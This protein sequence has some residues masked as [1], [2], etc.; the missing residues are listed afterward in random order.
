MGELILVPFW[1]YTPIERKAHRLAAIKKLKQYAAVK[2]KI[3]FADCV[4]RDLIVGDEDAGDTANLPVDIQDAPAGTEQR[5]S[6]RGW[7]Q[8][9]SD[10]TAETLDLIYD[11]AVHDDQVIGIIGFVD[12]SGVGGVGTSGD[13]LYMRIRDRNNI[14]AF[15]NCQRVYAG[16][17][18]YGG[19]FVDQDTGEPGILVFDEND[20]LMIEVAVVTATTDRQVVFEALVAEKVGNILT[21]TPAARAV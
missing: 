5:T 4:V 19:Y 7:A 17:A 1:E 2:L 15:F 12:C 13:L 14:K 9:A 21:G 18:P 20:Q 8:D 3:R 16:E 11:D 10:L 6:I